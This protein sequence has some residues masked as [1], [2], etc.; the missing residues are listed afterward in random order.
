MNLINFFAD[1]PSSI[2]VIIL[3]M[4]PVMELRGSIPLA[5]GIYQMPIWQAFVF[6]IIGSVL[7]TVIILYF[8]ESATK[9]L[10][11]TRIGK[12]FFE[13]LFERTREKFAGKYQKYGEV[14]LMIFV[15]IPLPVT[16]VWTG[17]LAA[18][19]FGIQRK[20]AIF[21]IALGAIIAGIIVSLLTYFGFFVVRNI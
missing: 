4:I 2:S 11:K 10:M 15:A 19:L 20:R 6:S 3:S 17:S 1:F 8:L 13:W 12:R 5:V 9:L 18:Y 16:G 21:F 7:V 14:A